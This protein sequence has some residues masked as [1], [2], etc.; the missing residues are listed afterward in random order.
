MSDPRIKL[1]ILRL[2][3]WLV[4]KDYRAVEAFT[5]GVRLT[6]PVLQQAI[7]EYGKTLIMPPDRALEELDV[8]EIENSSPKAWSVRVDLW[9]AE[10]GPSDLSME[11][12][13]ID[14]EGRFLATE[15]DNVHVL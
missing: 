11:C 6:A 7:A 5:K 15:V 1:T 9:T 4:A 12:T 14:R 13:L 3:Q 10:E 2:L 8:I